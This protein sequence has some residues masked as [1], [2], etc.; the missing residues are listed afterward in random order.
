VLP[1]TCWPARADWHALTRPA[2]WP[3]CA[4]LRVACAMSSVRHFPSFYTR[5]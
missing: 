3:A 2:F 5:P 4:A 1:D